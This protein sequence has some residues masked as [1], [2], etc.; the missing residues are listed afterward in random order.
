MTITCEGKHQMSRTHNRKRSPNDPPEQPAFY[1]PPPPAFY[2]A[3]PPVFHA[4]PP[5]PY[6]SVRV[7]HDKNASVANVSAVKPGDRLPGYDYK[8]SGSAKREKGDVHDEVTGELLALARAFEDLSRQ[9]RRD[10]AKRV[11]ASSKA[12]A[13]ERRRVS[14]KRAKARELPVHRT[15]AEWEE[16]QA[17]AQAAQRAVMM[18]EILGPAI[19]RLEA[20]VGEAHVEEAFSGFHDTGTGRHRRKSPDTVDCKVHGIREALSVPGLTGGEPVCVL[21]I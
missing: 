19:E 21:C 11:K 15:L 4:A 12:V 16:I 18:A 10:A 7:L 3:P 2:A 14:A 20:H 1:A 17:R 9:L 5:V 6:V 13:D 8:A